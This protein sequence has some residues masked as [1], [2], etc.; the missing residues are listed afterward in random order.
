ML[1]QA[2]GADFFFAFFPT[3]SRR[4]GQALCYSEIEFYIN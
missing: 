3:P 4:G 2:K 1:G